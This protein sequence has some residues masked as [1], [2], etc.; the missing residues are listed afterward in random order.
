M[1]V[2]RI[3]TVMFY[4]SDLVGG[5]TAFPNMGVAVPP[6]A[7]SAVFWYNLDR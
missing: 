3:A 2:F 1:V 7:G 4:L 5:Y 6:R